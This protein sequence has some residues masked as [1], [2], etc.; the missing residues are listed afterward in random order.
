MTTTPFLDQLDELRSTCQGAVLLPTDPGYDASRHTWN[1]AVDH[2][3]AVIVRCADTSDI[4][5]A[6]DFARR[7]DLPVSMRAGGHDVA[8]HAEVEHSIMLDL[9][10][11]KTI[12]IDPVHRRGTV[13]PGV[14][15]TE[16]DR[17]AQAHGLAV[18]G[19]DVSTVG[20]IGTAMSGGTGWLQRA[21]G[22]TC[23]NV[24]AADIV[25]ADGRQ[26]RAD[27]DHHPDLLWALRGGGGNFGVVTGLELRLHP[28]GTV[29]AGTLLYRFDKARAVLTAFRELCATAPA[30]LSLR[31][32]LINWPPTAPKGP[33]MAAIT[34]SYLGSAEDARAALRP[35]R[36]IGE[37]E[38]DLMRPLS[39]PELQS[40]T[41]QAFT[42]GHATA[43]GTEW[44]RALDDHTIDALIDLA[45]R[46]PT[47]HTLISIHQL[48]GA[49]RRTTN[50]ATAFSFHEANYHLVVFSGAP[51][52]RQL[53][54]SQRWITDIIETVQNC[55][56]GGPYLGILDGSS[57]PSRIRSC[58]HPDA[59]QRLQRVKAEYDPHNLFRCNHNIAPAGARPDAEAR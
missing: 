40:N 49:T 30:E 22:F 57:S 46:I 17:A 4:H 5:A 15:W 36:R 56:A 50:Q 10:P 16:F 27:A 37:P 53:V 21:L 2:R 55:S 29:Y 43:T 11:L 41:E 31:A 19:A 33:P 44:L 14:T 54:T 6:V 42:E 48:G 38:L 3:P 28:I 12:T 58:F 7:R 35:L 9:S 13:A 39:Y 25:L 51:S 47:P 45:A 23:D 8:D 26:V 52:G 20:V 34:A 18:T 24:L 59:Y 32:T 1:T